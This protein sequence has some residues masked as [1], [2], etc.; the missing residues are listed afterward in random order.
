MYN[1]F[2]QLWTAKVPDH[3]YLALPPPPPDDTPIRCPRCG[4]SSIHAHRRGF[5]FWQGIIGMNK[6]LTTCLRCGLRFAPYKEFH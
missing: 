2:S 1:W 5:T 6:I 4:S 3:P